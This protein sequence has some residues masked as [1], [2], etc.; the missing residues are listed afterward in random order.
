MK[1]S[2]LT[3]KQAVKI[4]KKRYSRKNAVKE[5]DKA[6]S[7]YIRARDGKCMQGGNCNGPL[8]CGHLITRSNYSTRWDEGNAFGQ[9]SGHNFSQG[10]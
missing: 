6:F 4:L 5:L 2:A 10:W 3:K 9:C 7:E 8:T 1:T